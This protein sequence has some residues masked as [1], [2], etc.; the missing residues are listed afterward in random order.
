[1][2]LG[3][4]K[5]ERGSIR[6]YEENGKYLEASRWIPDVVFMYPCGNYLLEGT[7]RENILLINLTL[8]IKK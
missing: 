2:L 6:L 4:F 1:M 8:Q 5:P 7:L 3:V